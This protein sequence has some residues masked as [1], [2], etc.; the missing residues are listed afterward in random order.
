MSEELAPNVIESA[1]LNIEPWP[2][3]AGIVSAKST[4][5]GS[6][7]STADVV[8]VRWSDGSELPFYRESGAWASL[9]GARGRPYFLFFSKVYTSADRPRALVIWNE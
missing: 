5:L 4:F 3:T 2:F 8:I 9:S 1:W 7:I 6:K